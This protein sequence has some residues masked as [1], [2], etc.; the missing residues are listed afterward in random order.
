MSFLSLP[1]VD[2][3][4]RAPT[5]PAILP[6]GESPREEFQFTL[7]KMLALVG[8]IGIELAMARSNLGLAVLLAAAAF[9][10]ILLRANQPIVKIL[11]GLLCSAALGIAIVGGQDVVW[12]G[13][14][15]LTVKVLVVDATS[16]TPIPNATVELWEGPPT[17]FEAISPRFNTDFRQ[18]E[19]EGISEP[20]LTD[21]DGRTTFSHRFPASG[22]KSIFG[23]RG[24]VYTNGRW[25]RVTAPGRITT[26]LSLDQQSPV[27]RDVDDALPLVVKVP[28]GKAVNP[29][30][31][32]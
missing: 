4:A 6:D 26:L 13:G 19:I 25:L 5:D 14:K 15:D 12:D 10:W 11:A 22:R 24:R 3:N 1:H 18:L 7:G 23:E 2:S 21:S 31:S 16:L 20:L 28:V 30:G 29:G 32:E 8:F 27:P 17:V 9:A